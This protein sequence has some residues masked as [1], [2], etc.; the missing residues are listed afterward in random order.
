[1][2]NSLRIFLLCHTS[3]HSPYIYS[4]QLCSHPSRLAL[5]SSKNKI[6]TYYTSCVKTT[7]IFSLMFSTSTVNTPNYL[8]TLFVFCIILHLGTHISYC[9]WNI[10]RTEQKNQIFIILTTLFPKIFQMFSFLIRKFSWHTKHSNSFTI[11]E[12]G[13]IPHIGV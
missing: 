1:M 9:W 5:N 10:N 2:I 13:I 6:E 4:I 12:N 8:K 7:N 11:E 3:F